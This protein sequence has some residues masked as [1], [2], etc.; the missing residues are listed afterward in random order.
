MGECK[1]PSLDVFRESCG[2]EE[3]GVIDEES[4]TGNVAIERIVEVGDRVR[5]G[6][7]D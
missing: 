5:E 3:E 4:F 6:V 7:G 1:A 2:R